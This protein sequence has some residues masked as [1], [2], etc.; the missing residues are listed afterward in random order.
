MDAYAKSKTPPNLRDKRSTPRWAFN[1][2]CEAVGMRPIHDVCAEPHTAMVSHYWTEEDDALTLSWYAEIKASE[3]LRD[4]T[5]PV[6]WMNCPYSDPGAWCAKAAEEAYNGMIIIG[7]LPDDRSTLWY[8]R[9]IHGVA[10]TVFLT[11]SR[12]Q[13]DSPGQ[14]PG[15]GSNP[16]GSIVPIWTPWCTG[17]TQEVYIPMD[18]WAKHKPQRRKAA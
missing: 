1:A 13:F 5:F 17:Q 3:A 14:E 12:I 7:L 4:G 9:H 6:A 16:K 11:P 18:I 15:T 10:P 8:Q 2:I